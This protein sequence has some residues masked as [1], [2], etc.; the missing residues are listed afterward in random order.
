MAPTE[1]WPFSTPLVDQHRHAALWLFG[2]PRVDSDG[3]RRR[4]YASLSAFSG[5]SKAHGEFAATFASR[6]DAAMRDPPPRRPCPRRT[7]AS[8]G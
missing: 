1:E 6:L 2:T 4:A 3:A 8:N 5:R 7:A